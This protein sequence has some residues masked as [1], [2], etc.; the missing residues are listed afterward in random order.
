MSGYT[1]LVTGL[2]RTVGSV[3]HAARLRTCHL[4]L[5]A[6]RLKSV[7]RAP[8]HSCTLSQTSNSPV[9]LAFVE[10]GLK[11]R[12]PNGTGGSLNRSASCTGH[13]RRMLNEVLIPNGL[14]L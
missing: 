8:M 2:Y 14:L 6:G 7:A 12:T 3:V 11:L 10:S 4:E 13:S 1:G 9:S 5:A